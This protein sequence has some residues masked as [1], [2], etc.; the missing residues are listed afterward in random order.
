VSSGDSQAEA[1]EVVPY[2]PAWP[3]Q[4]ELEKHL[5]QTAL[6]PW[7]VGEIEHIGSTAVVG[8]SAKA[9]IDI[10]APV[11]SLSASL[12]AIPA[13]SVAG[14]LH[15]P[16]RADVMHW[17]CKP[18]PQ[19]RTHHLHLVP[20]GSDLWL[21]RLAFR[22]TLRTNPELAAE[23]AELKLR[24]AERYRHDREAYTEHKEPFVRRVLL[25]CGRAQRSS[26]N[27]SEGP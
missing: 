10:M 17:F 1:I 21:E 25:S 5:I 18:S 19:V 11:A 15:H 14:Y 26:S 4:F 6:S 12:A 7:L 27:C 3:D 24:L 9:V 22:N 16:Y 8:L 23:Y 2:D 13:A 20:L